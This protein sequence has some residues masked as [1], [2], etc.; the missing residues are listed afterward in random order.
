LT[1][2]ST[3]NL[4]Y[5]LGDIVFFLAVPA[6][7]VVVGCD[8]LM[9]GSK[10]SKYFDPDISCRP[11]VSIYEKVDFAIV[12]MKVANAALAIIFSFSVVEGKGMPSLTLT[13]P[14]EIRQYKD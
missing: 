6:E 13:A 5:H 10:F 11:L 9:W 2:L 12:H 1:I 8:L 14:N 4:Q 3:G 7:G